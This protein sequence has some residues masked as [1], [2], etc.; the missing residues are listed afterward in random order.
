M[1]YD[2]NWKPCDL[3]TANALLSGS[4]EPGK[5]WKFDGQYLPQN[6]SASM[7]QR[8]QVD[9]YV[10]GSVNPTQIEPGITALGEMAAMRFQGDE[11]ISY[12]WLFAVSGSGDNSQV[13]FGGFFY[14]FDAHHF[15][16]GSRPVEDIFIKPHPKLPRT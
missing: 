6:I 13:V 8:G 2:F 12:R 11:A 5:L 4:N 3:T 14:K 10:S 9:F 1:S 7:S 16:S 15:Q